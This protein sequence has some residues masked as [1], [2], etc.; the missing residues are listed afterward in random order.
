MQGSLPRSVPESIY[1]VLA[2]GPSPAMLSLA[3]AAL[4]FSAPP[5]SKVSLSRRDAL[6]QAI[7]AVAVFAPTTAAFAVSART[8]AAS[9]LTG[10]CEQYHC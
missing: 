8:G 3:C 1:L 7:G 2:R 4:A 5:T 6:V 10:E 9:P